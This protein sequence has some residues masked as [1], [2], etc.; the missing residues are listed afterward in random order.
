MAELEAQA[1]RQA[2]L[3]AAAA[4]QARLLRASQQEQGWMNYLQTLEDS[5]KVGLL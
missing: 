2:A 1:E 4:A 5:S 3:A